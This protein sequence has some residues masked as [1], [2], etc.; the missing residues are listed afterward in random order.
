[1]IKLLSTWIWNRWIRN[2]KTETGISEDQ[3]AISESSV[4][5]V[6][7]DAEITEHDLLII[8][9]SIFDFVDVKTINTTKIHSGLC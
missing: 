5:S 4:D 6:E 2:A 1:M 8:G 9:D 7:V 3:D